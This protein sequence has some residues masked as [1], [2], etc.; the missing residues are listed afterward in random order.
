MRG[1]DEDPSG[2][3]AAVTSGLSALFAVAVAF[4]VP[5][6][7]TQQTALLGLALVAA[8]WVTQAWVRKYAWSPESH[9]RA[10]DL[11]LQETVVRGKLRR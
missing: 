5:L 1:R 7:D 8:P 11:A 6:T 2:V 4:G 3:G 9:S 10:V